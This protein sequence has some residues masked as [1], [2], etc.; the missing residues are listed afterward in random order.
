MNSKKD[1]QFIDKYIPL[2]GELVKRDL[3]LKY[4]RSVLGYLWSLLNPLLMMLVMVVVFSYMFRFDI[5]NYALY[6]IC[7]Q[8]MFNFFNEAT[9]K[10]MFAIIDNGA[11][12]KKIYVPKYIFPISRVLSCFVTM[13]FSLLAI[14][15]VMLAT[16]VRFHLT[17]LI[18]WIPLL[19]LLVF[20]CGVGMILSALSVKFRDVTHLYGVLT[21]AWMYATP[22]FYPISAVPK[23]VAFIIRLNPLYI[24]ID[25]FRELVL[26]GSVPGIGMWLAGAWMAVTMFGVGALIFRGKQDDFIYYI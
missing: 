24:F 7:G 13:S 18:F 4:R 21:M 5:D 19:Y 25:L 15:I 23:S 6:L 17:M 12:I 20:S 8:T 10:S 2:I 22:I 1:R 14:V 9:N 26:Y 16:H 3:R 11:L